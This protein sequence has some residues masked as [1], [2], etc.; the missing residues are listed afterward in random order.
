MVRLKLPWWLLMDWWLFCTR[1]SAVI[2]MAYA[3]RRISRVPSP[4]YAG[5][6]CLN[7]EVNLSIM[8]HMTSSYDG[9]NVYILLP[10]SWSQNWSG[11]LSYLSVSPPTGLCAWLSVCIA[12]LIHDDVIKWKHFPRYWPFVRG[13]HWCPVNSAHKGQWRG[14]LMLSLI[15]VWKNA[16]VNNRDA[17]DLRRYRAHYDVI[18]MDC[19]GG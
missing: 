15:R 3:S 12:Q 7:S 14:A 11:I 2:V 16:W 17:G 1:A 18:T 13:I 5:W 10:D 9:K 4:N 6:I 19:V 8:I